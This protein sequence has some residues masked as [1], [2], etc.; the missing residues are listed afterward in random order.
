MRTEIITDFCGVR[1]VLQQLAVSGVSLYRRASNALKSDFYMDDCLSG[2]DNTESA[3]Q[4]QQ[5]LIELC[6]SGGFLLRKWASNEVDLMLSV[7]ADHREMPV[8]MD[9]SASVKT[10]GLLWFTAKDCFG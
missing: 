10:L 7:E 8:S 2:A 5:E 4:L 9:L 3:L 1:K 6:K